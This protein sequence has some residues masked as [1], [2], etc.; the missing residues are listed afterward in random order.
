VPGPPVSI[1]CNVILSPGAAGPPDSGVVVAVTQT[2]V[3][4]GGLPLAVVGQTI[5][6]MINSV[7]GAPY[8]A[9][10]V[11]GGSVSVT[12]SGQGLIRVGDILP[13][14]SGLMTILGPPAAPW[15]TDKGA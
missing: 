4:A 5:C 9:T 3:T 10:P 6:S 2:T 15:I 13:A 11:A 12:L 14:G 8:P 7:S 1:G